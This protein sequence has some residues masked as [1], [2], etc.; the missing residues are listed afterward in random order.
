MI[1][2]DQPWLKQLFASELCSFLKV[3]PIEAPKLDDF[4]AFDTKGILKNR[5]FPTQKG[6]LIDVYIYSLGLP[7]F[8][9]FQWAFSGSMFVFSGVCWWKACGIPEMSNDKCTILSC[10]VIT[11]D[12]EVIFSDETEVHRCWQPDQNRCTVHEV[13]FNLV[14]HFLKQHLKRYLPLT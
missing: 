12:T 2:V 6:D 1:T 13:Q 5:P 11:A 3:N 14:S 9:F 4:W 7:C 8:S 10:L